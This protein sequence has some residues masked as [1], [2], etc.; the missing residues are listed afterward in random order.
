V[1]PPPF[2]YRAVRSV[3]EAVG[4]LGGSAGEARLLAGGQ[5]LLPLLKLR[6]VRPALLIDL[7]RV[8]GLDHVTEVDGSLAFGAL[9]RLAE[10]ETGRVR[11]R[12][13]LLHAAA[14]HIGHPAIRN[15][16][17]VCGSL[18]HADPAAELPILALALEAELRAVGPDGPRAIA[19]RDFFVSFFETSLHPGEV[20]VESR[21]PIPPPGTGWAFQEISR[22]MG[23]FALAA[24][25]VVLE[26]A[27]DGTVHRPRIAV[28]AVAD[29]ALRCLEAEAMLGGQP[30]TVDRF[31]AAAA[32]AAAP[33]DPPS[34][35]HASGAY[36]RRVTV[37]LVERAL[38]EAW[39]RA[40]Q[41]GA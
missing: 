18:A 10:L 13:P 20:L 9:A 7:N 24:V 5:S 1:K 28:G 32:A 26:R 19:A 37:V 25:A 38:S 21:F 12:L 29:R 23:D 4:L 14:R 41:A 16:G 3:E 11:D 34:D 15:R 8:A 27:A 30:G 39:A 33:L 36:R 35:V 40:G 6:L 2:D 17:T 22:R 31:R